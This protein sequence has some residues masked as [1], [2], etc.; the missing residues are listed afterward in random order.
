MRPRAWRCEASTAAAVRT[1]P[2]L[3]PTSL[4]RDVRGLAVMGLPPA[5]Y[6]GGSIQRVDLD[7]GLVS[8]LYDHCAG[9]KLRGPNDIVFDAG[10]GFWFTDMG[11]SWPRTHDHGGVYYAR[12]D[13][14]LLEE[15]LFPLLTPNGIALSP[16]G[17][18]LYVAETLSGRV[19][20][21][22]V[23]APGKLGKG[24]KGPRGARLVHGFDGYQ[25]LDSMAV[26]AQGNI[27]VATLLTA[28]ISVL[29]PEGRLLEQVAIPGDDPFI[30]NI[31]FGGEDLRTAYI[32]GSGR[33]RLY[34]T[35][36]RC[37]GLRL[38]FER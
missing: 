17:R 26:D 22:P 20:A 33:G 2:P 3:V 32:T 5:D 16:D 18:E 12:A 4:W 25:L 21:W 1:V 31:C 34:A 28:A 15:V 37:P 38:P 14:A 10:G 24:G 13:G 36:W 7:T 30:T 35:E 29:T 11:K 9:E 8:T 6:A 23:V 27:C 19:W